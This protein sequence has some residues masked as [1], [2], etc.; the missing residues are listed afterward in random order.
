MR[1]LPLL[2]DYPKRRWTARRPRTVAVRRR[3]IV[4]AAAAGL[5]LSA[6][7][8]A[9]LWY[10]VAQDEIAL[11][12]LERQAVLKRGYEDTI[13]ALRSRLD[14]ASERRS[15]EQQALDARLQ[16]LL[17]R[18][19]AFESRQATVQSLSERTGSLAESSR[20]DLREIAPSV[21]AY[22]PTEAPVLPE[23][24]QLRLSPGAAPRDQRSSL[25]TIRLGLDGAERRLRALEVAQ[26]RSLETLAADAE[27]H[28]RRILKAIRKV[29][30]D[31]QSVDPPA[32]GLG[33]P[34]VAAEASGD[35]DLMVQR[36]AASV[37]RLGRLRRSVGALPFA[38]PIRG[39]IDLSSGFGY[40]VDPFTRSP[41][42]HTGLDFRA[43][44]GAPV[45]ASGA[46]RVVAADYSGAYGNMVEIDH[47]HGVVSRYAHL[48]TIG[49]QTGQEVRL[50]A[51]L[52]RVGSTGRSTGPH[53]HYETRINDTAVDPQRFLKAAAIID[54]MLITE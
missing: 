18:Q 12:L 24:F 4:A 50:G 51:V 1:P 41:A 15:A 29:G 7:S 32:S 42:M 31:P 35:L 30:L 14:Q 34:L 43:E 49:V 36:A 20:G 45:R 28:G 54:G 48:S 5:L 9:S 23:P 47:G 19:A 25:D 38:E 37:A 11:K 39:E 10:F 53:L 16:S 26:A 27:G 13:A 6:W 44:H 33:G 21:S 22:V 2:V 40:R 3:T 46:G 17:A 8:G 52:G